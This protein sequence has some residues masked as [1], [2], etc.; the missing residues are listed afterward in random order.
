MCDFDDKL[1]FDNQIQNTQTERG[2]CMQPGGQ[3]EKIDGG[4]EMTL[5]VS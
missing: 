5:L 2:V 4:Q 3:G 1:N